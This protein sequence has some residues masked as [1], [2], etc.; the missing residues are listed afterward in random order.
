MNA[1]EM[2]IIGS[3]PIEGRPSSYGGTTVLFRSFVDYLD[4]KGI[5]YQLVQLNDAKYA[6]RLLPM[7][8]AMMTILV[9]DKSCRTVMLH[10]ADKSTFYLAP[11]LWCLARV[12]GRKF[13]FRKFGGAFDVMYNSAPWWK[14][15]LVK[16]TIFS[17]NLFYVETRHLK[18][19]SSTVGV[20]SVSWFPNVRKSAVA[21]I[22]LNAKEYSKKLVYIG[23]V[24][25]TKGLRVILEASKKMDNSFIIDVYGPMDDGS[26][27][28]GDFLN[29][30]VKYKGVLS[31][32]EVVTTLSQYDV[33]LLPSKHPGEGYPGIIIEAFSV[34]VV[35]VA[36]RWGGIPELIENGVNGVLIEDFDAEALLEALAKVSESNYSDLSRAARES[37]GL[38]DAS[39]VHTRVLSEINNLFI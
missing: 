31:P 14:C 37:Y 25:E 7:L 18:C 39:I 8:V 28:E 30:K 5:A 6:Y 15:Q 27:K 13:V 22:D 38:Y 4:E 16:Y 24:K 20:K 29:S 32:A 33:L 23:S 35:P 3:L 19:W 11:I 26:I 10:G 12:T 2:I 1:R 34:G 36:T 9:E 17:S 21:A